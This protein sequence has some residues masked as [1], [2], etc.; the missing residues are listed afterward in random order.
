VDGYEDDDAGRRTF[1]RD[2]AMLSSAGI[3]LASGDYSAPDY[4]YSLSEWQTVPDFTPAE[5]SVLGLAAVA[6]RDSS[7][8]KQAQLTSVRLQAGAPSVLTS[9]R[10]Q[11][12]LPAD[13]DMLLAVSHAIAHRSAL[14]FAY[15][16][17]RGEQST[18]IMWPWTAS[19]FGE[20]WYAA[21][22]DLRRHEPRIFRFSRMSHVE[23]V[24][25]DEA[26]R[27]DPVPLAER[28]ALLRA[29]FRGIPRTARPDVVVAIPPERIPWI[30][31]LGEPHLVD[32]LPS[33]WEAHRLPGRLTSSVIREVLENPGEAILLSPADA[34]KRLND[35]ISAVESAH[36]GPGLDPEDLPR[37]RGQRAVFSP[38]DRVH[39]AFTLLQ[40]LGEHGT[41]TVTELAELLRLDPEAVR[42]DLLALTCVGQGPEDAGVFDVLL[43]EDGSVT[44]GET[45]GFDVAPMPPVADLIPLII[46]LGEMASAAP[47]GDALGT[48]SQSAQLKLLRSA[49]DPV[50]AQSLLAARDSD[51]DSDAFSA[52][53][54]GERTR[55]VLTALQTGSPL[56]FRY[57]K[58]TEAESTWRIVMP[59]A[60]RTDRGRDYLLAE[61]LRDGR[62]K[63]F[64]L[65]RCVHLESSTETPLVDDSPEPRSA[66]SIQ[67]RWGSPRRSR[68]QAQAWLSVRADS[69]RSARVLLESF[70]ARGLRSA[71]DGRIVGEVNMASTSLAGEI[72]G[73]AGG[74][75]I[76][77]PA[78]FRQEILDQCAL[79][80][81]VQG[82]GGKID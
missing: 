4:R 70:R 30:R 58:K 77:K 78:R 15:V 23:P 18:R 6:L 41:S 3:K 54:P 80:R 16:N 36:T 64:R 48:A 72:L 38:T 21:G 19:V 65:D 42:A 69:D 25:A 5:R 24:P 68:A 7:A 34:V 63:F 12:R 17:G 33:A 56:I 2:R 66:E 40:L 53:G 62:E 45:E 39:R 46:A 51:E 79:L 31:E 9:E 57:L 27:R 13:S 37:L 8:R 71:P 26:P 29:L 22:F 1:H 28:P 32:D 20:A 44:L 82:L 14:S 43:H 52:H 59:R 61:D 81:K 60:L 76:E 75:A 35:A 55:T 73:S 10:W 47:P 50:I 67:P 49:E 11:P 74:L